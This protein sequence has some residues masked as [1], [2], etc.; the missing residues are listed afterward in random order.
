[1]DDNAIQF[2][3]SAKVVS[4]KVKTALS[5]IVKRKHELQQLATT[6]QQRDGRIRQITA[7]QERVR[8]NMD[9]LDHTSELYK[10]YVKK[11]TDQEEEVAKLNEEIASLA[12]QEARQRKALDEYMMGLDLQ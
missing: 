3:E 5:E 8:Q 9:R 1:L 2:Y 6:R 4:E 10:K 11:F 7:D 12:E